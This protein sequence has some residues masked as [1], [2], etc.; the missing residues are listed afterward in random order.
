MAPLWPGKATR[1]LVRLKSRP[2]Y[3][4]TRQLEGYKTNIFATIPLFPLKW[5]ISLQPVCG[6]GMFGWKSLIEIQ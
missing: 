2:I 3:V 5:L 4:L 6:V 1:P